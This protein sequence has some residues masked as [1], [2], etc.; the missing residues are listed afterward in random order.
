MPQSV[1]GACG[2]R[3]FTPTRVGNAFAANMFTDVNPVH[4]HA[5]GEC[6]IPAASNVFPFGSPPR[7]WG[8][9]TAAPMSLLSRRFTPT[10][11]GNATPLPPTNSLSSVHPHACG[12]CTTPSALKCEVGGS[13]PRVWGMHRGQH[14]IRRGRRFTPTRVGNA[15]PHKPPARSA[16]VH[17]HA[18]GE[19]SLLSFFPWGMSGSPPRVWGMRP[20]RMRPSSDSRFTP[21]RVGNAPCRRGIRAPESVHPHACGEC[22]MAPL[23]SLFDGG[24]PPRVWGMHALPLPGYRRSRF[25]PTRVGNAI[26]IGGFYHAITVH[27]HACGECRRWRRTR[28]CKCG[29]PPRVWGMRL[30]LAHRTRPRRFTPT[31][32][33]NATKARPVHGPSSVH[34]HACGECLD[35][36]ERMLAQGGSPPRVWGMRRHGRR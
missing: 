15:L 32:V 14:R 29:S 31:R 19:C 26:I 34:P 5:C 8:M 25:T 9:H 28:R 2:L 6:P 35:A 10:R 33:G 17:P 20:S 4:P 24:S 27:P 23:K 1:V 16:P 36:I 11:V 22:V 3:R 12:E 13:P 18:C 30:S 7:V 21:T